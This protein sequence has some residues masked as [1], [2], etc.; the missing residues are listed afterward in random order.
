MEE[1][2]DRRRQ[3]KRQLQGGGGEEEGE[4]SGVLRPSLPMGRV[5]KMVKLDREI[6]KVNSEALFLI[7]LSTD[8]FLQSLVSGARDAALVSKRR[9]I[10]LDHLHSAACSHPPTS[11]FL[12]DSLAR[13]APPS[14][15]AARPRPAAA[16]AEKPLPPGARRIDDFFRKPSADP[17]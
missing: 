13:P 9:T 17:Q 15:P 10:K 3:Q 6:K 11:D 14:H 1:Q 5:K 7:S 8:L 16:A 2:E 4:S 12:L